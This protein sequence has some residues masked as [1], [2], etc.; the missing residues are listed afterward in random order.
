M[1]YREY[2]SIVEFSYNKRE[3][4]FVIRFLDNNSYVLKIT[5]LP[6][7]MQTKKPKW[8]ETR[9][10]TDRGSLLV[11]VGNDFRPIP[12]NVIHSRGVQV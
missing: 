12:F 6:K 1:D 3:E 10:S 4:Q 11:P 7:K 5:E 9:L 2:A 8:E